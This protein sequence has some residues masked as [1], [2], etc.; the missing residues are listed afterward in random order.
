MVR[1][2]N[3]KINKEIIYEPKLD[4][5]E[6]IKICMERFIPLDDADLN[7]RDLSN[8]NLTDAC[9]DGAQL[10]NANLE[11]AD[12]TGASLQGAMLNDAMLDNATLEKADLT[13]AKLIGASFKGAKLK[14]ADFSHAR[15]SQSKFTNSDLTGVDFSDS[16]TDYVD[17]EGAT[18]KNAN[19]K[20]MDG[21]NTRMNF[22]YLKGANLENA[23]FP[24]ELRFSNLRGAILQNANLSNTYIG[25]TDLT[26]ARME[27][28]NLEG[29]AFLTTVL[30]K[31]KLMDAVFNSSTFN[32]CSFYQ[33]HFTHK[34]AGYPNDIN[35][36]LSELKI[37]HSNEKDHIP[38]PLIKFITDHNSQIN[39]EIKSISN[40]DFKNI[41]LNGADLNGTNIMETDF[42]SGEMRY[43]DLSGLDS[44]C[45]DIY[46]KTDL[47]G[48]RLPVGF[49]ITSDNEN[50]P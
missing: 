44:N 25:Q 35:E 11:G 5:R 3:W 36:A 46:S 45:F 20:D 42:Y 37:P 38:T 47:T 43:C 28:A 22:M 1:I 29:S 34:S 7:G 21:V 31:V 19:L 33:T 30:K 49:Q 17:F 13:R 23:T 41:V 40:C 26:A 18:L 10:K 15:L 9:L 50:P 2:I 27:E 12:L 6:T 39:L 24:Q 48:T 32:N 14:G 4:F 16:N 8:L